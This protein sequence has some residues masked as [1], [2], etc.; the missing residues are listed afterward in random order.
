MSEKK[1]FKHMNHDSARQLSGAIVK[2]AVTDY[3]DA[4]IQNDTVAIA[5]CE[6]FFSN[7]D[8]WFGW[9]SNDLD[10]ENIAKLIRQKVALFIKAVECHQPERY[11]DKEAAKKASFT[12][13]CCGDKNTS[14]LITFPKRKTKQENVITYT[15]PSC[16]I[17]LW[18][19]WNVGVVLREQSCNNCKHCVS[20]GI[21]ETCMITDKVIRRRVNYCDN[22]EGK[23]REPIS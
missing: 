15:C 7:K 19:Q 10:G 23:E 13:P 17:S 1:R 14:V 22:W 9:L 3:M 11:G 20:N 2:Q 5:D 16:H 4:L 18:Y 21:E 8:G 12:C 6:K